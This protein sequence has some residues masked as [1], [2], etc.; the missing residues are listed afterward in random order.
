MVLSKQ[1]M[2]THDARLTKLKITPKCQKTKLSYHLK[3]YDRKKERNVTRKF[4]FS[5]VAAISFSLNYFDNPVGAEVCGFYEIFDRE[6]KEELL[7]QNFA[8]RKQGFLQHGDYAY[9]PLE[10]SDLLN[11]RT[12]FERTL[13]KLDSYRLFEQQTTG[14]IYRILA[15]KWEVR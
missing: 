6:A 5:G 2:V 3:I 10:Q 15:K 11:E 13:A 8:A 9:D 4:C 7:E 1:L 12:M 14:G